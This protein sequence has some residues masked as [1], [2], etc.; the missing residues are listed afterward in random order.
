MMMDQPRLIL[1][2]LRFIFSFM[3][4]ILKHSS[5]MEVKEMTNT[6]H[7]ITDGQAEYLDNLRRLKKSGVRVTIDGKEMP[8]EKWP[9]IFKIAETPAEANSFY[10]ADYIAEPFGWI[11]EIR[12]DRIRI[13]YLD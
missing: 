1:G 5:R 10:M 7:L 8:E 12:L 9:E 4:H 3:C 2:K 13:H 6:I 11:K